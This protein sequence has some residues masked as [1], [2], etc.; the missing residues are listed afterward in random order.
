MLKELLKCF[1]QTSGFNVLLSHTGRDPG[2]G[3]WVNG[4]VL[5]VGG[6]LA[7]SLG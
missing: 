5:S 1:Y 2:S 3:S 4:Q 7:H 6:C